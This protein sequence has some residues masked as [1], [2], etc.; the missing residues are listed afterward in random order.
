MNYDIQRKKFDQHFCKQQIL[1]FTDIK[2]NKSVKTDSDI[3]T[4]YIL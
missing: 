4:R 3:E 1:L 2:H